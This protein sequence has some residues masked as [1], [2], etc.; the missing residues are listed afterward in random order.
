MRKSV[1]VVA[2]MLSVLL[3]AWMGCAAKPGTS[4]PKQAS[5]APTKPTRSVLI[6]DFE[7]Y[8]SDEQLAKAWYKPPHGGTIHQSRESVIK[9]SG[10]FSMKV[11]YS[12]TKSRDKGTGLGLSIS[13]GIVKDHGGKLSVESEVGQ[14]TR[15][16]V[17]LKTT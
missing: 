16:H 8:A 12:T 10:N 2:G 11:E 4:T 3:L 6:E 13:H 5:A 17:D 7:S 1:A 9:S 14:W 15:F